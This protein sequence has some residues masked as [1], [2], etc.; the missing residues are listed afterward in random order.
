MIK[1]ILHIGK[2]YYPFKGGTEEVSQDCV[3]AL[4]DKYEQE[5]ICFNHEPGDRTDYVDGIK[6]VR[7]GCFAKIA[8]QSLSVSY[9]KKLKEMIRTF[10]PDI[11]LLHYP[12]P[13]AT[14]YL[15]KY[16]GNVVRIVVYWHLDIVKQKVLRMF[17]RRQNMS[18][19]ERADIVI[20][21]SPNYVEGSRYLQAVKDKCR[22]IPNCVN[23]DR[24]AMSEKAVEIANRIRKSNEG[25]I[26]CFAFG[27]HT[28]YKGFDYL[29]EAAGLLDDRFR[30]YIGGCGE[31]TERLR[32]KARKDK[33]VVFLGRMSDD[34]LKGMMCAMDIY[35][36]S[37]VTKNEAFGISLAEAMYFRKPAVT[38]TIPGSGVN[39][40]CRSGLEG[41]EVP[42]RDVQ[43]YAGA[44]IRL[45]EYPDLRKE[46]GENG[47]R[48]VTEHFLLEQYNNNIRRTVDELWKNE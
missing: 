28:A 40:V 46:L 17:F 16:A 23:T 43:A 29:I 32:R 24:L 30:I 25:K 35:C 5:V 26:I 12:N 2:Y 7:C 36:F 48:R 22:I 10:Q 18:L 33:K 13:F 6:V 8:S 19:V 27:R 21:T 15:L 44:V 4:K 1:R 38:F 41:L 47:Y 11:I 42:N 34:A 37:S 45:S 39:Y 31:E 14:H 9:G 20:S 3:K